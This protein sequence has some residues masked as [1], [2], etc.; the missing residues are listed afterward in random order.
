MHTLTTA[1]NPSSPQVATIALERWNAEAVEA[2]EALEAVDRDLADAAGQ[3]HWSQPTHPAQ[4]AAE[5]ALQ[6]NAELRHGLAGI[7]P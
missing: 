4:L 2:N 6:N 7:R 3:L 1:R 5:A